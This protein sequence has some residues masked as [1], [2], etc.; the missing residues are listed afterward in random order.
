M[1]ARRNVIQARTSTR[2]VLVLYFAHLAL[3]L[4]QAALVPVA[5]KLFAFLFRILP[6]SHY[7]TAINTHKGQHVEHG[8]YYS[9]QKN[10]GE[11]TRRHQIRSCA[12]TEGVGEHICIACKVREGYN[13]QLGPSVSVDF[14]MWI[15][16]NRCRRPATIQWHINKGGVET[17]ELLLPCVFILEP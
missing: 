4:N 5:C 14:I 9:H 1:C 2:P 8:I 15:A 6:T 12:R 10:N 3:N 16:F 7:F 13:P 17:G 11:P